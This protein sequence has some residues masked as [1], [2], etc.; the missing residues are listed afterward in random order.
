M[1]LV[2]TDDI[3]RLGTIL[4]VW[5]HPD[6]E[7][8]GV[9]GLLAAAVRNGQT[10]ACVTATKGELGVQDKT[11]W[12][13]GRLAEIR[14]GELRQAYEVLGVRHHHWLDYPDGGCASAD[15]NEAADRLAEIIG[16]YQPD[17]I[18]TF[19]PDGL[20]GH[21]D[22]QAVSRWVSRAGA[23]SGGRAGIYHLVQTSQQYLALK[24]ADERLNIFFNTDKPPLA[25]ESGCDICFKL[26]NEL[27]DVKRRALE[28]MPSQ[29]EAMLGILG[30][31]LA[32][33]L[34]VEA[35]VRADD[36]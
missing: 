22:H 11:R 24:D 17:T 8:F 13:V 20:T 14:A 10:V 32:A 2:T 34:G 9:G 29:M 28:A 25:E 18:L 31:K 33:S 12:P 16:L 3:K 1:R 27:L 15:L 36:A 5:A 7:V 30:D 35:L 19:G 26:D 6:D 4:G 21:P 23:L